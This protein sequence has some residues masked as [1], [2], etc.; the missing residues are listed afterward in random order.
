M[1][2]IGIMKNAFKDFI[3]LLSIWL[4]ARVNPF[5]AAE[6]ID[7]WSKNLKRREF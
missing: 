1:K 2:I 7:E 4:M 6:M 3:Y 5:G